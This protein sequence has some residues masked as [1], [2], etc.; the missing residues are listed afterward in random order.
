MYCFYNYLYH[1]ILPSKVQGFQFVY[2]PT[3]KYRYPALKQNLR[4]IAQLPGYYNIFALVK[5]CKQPKFSSTD[6]WI[7]RIIYLI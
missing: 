5:V 3:S 1:F 6:E 7:N 2:I 4:E